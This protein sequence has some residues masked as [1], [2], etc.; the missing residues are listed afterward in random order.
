MDYI[1]LIVW[2]IISMFALLNREAPS[3]RF[4][5][6]FNMPAFSLVDTLDM[7]NCTGHS[8]RY[9]NHTCFT[10]AKNDLDKNNLESLA[11]NGC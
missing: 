11:D 3:Q 4:H 8:N 6:D 10:M 2:S 7:K 5:S 9:L 1:T